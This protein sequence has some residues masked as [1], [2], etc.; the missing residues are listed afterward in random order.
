MAHPYSA[1]AKESMNSLGGFSLPITLLEITHPNL[2][3]PLRV[4][5]DTQDITSN[6]NLYTAMA[7]RLVPP[8]DLSQGQ[9]RARL[10]V[11]N[12]GRELTSWIESSGGGKNASVRIMQVRRAAPNTLELDITMQLDNVS[13]TMPEVSGDLGFPDIYNRPACTVLYTPT[14]APGLY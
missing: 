1:N 9:P 7:F 11:D 3:T 5:D 6:G 13:M 14:T 10:S 4:C 2:A 12:V 8:D